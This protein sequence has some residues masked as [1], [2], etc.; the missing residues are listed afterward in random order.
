M[1]PTLAQFRISALF[2]EDPAHRPHGWLTALPVLPEIIERHIL[3]H[4]NEQARF[5][6]FET[7]YPGKKV[8]SSP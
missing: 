8:L 1:V 7:M 2:R 6:A 3:R 4:G 5:E